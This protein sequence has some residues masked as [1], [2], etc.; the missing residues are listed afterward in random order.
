MSLLP[1][2]VPLVVSLFFLLVLITACEK[3]FWRI[4]SV[5]IMSTVEHNRHILSVSVY[6]FIVLKSIIHMWCDWIIPFANATFTHHYMEVKPH[7]SYPYN[8]WNIIHSRPILNYYQV[9]SINIKVPHLRKRQTP[10][11]ISYV[12]VIKCV[13]KWMWDGA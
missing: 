10:L 6:W 11:R 2:V 8:Y 9:N 3:Y 5:L 1:L 13:V 12:K 4:I 7:H